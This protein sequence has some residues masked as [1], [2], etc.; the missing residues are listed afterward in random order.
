MTANRPT[1]LPTDPAW[2]KRFNAAIHNPAKKFQ[3]QLAKK[4]QLMYCVG[5]GDLIWAMTTMCPDLAFASVKLSQANSCP[6]NVHYHAVK[7]TLQYLYSTKDDGIYFW[8]TSPCPKF[9]K[10]LN[11]TVNSNKQDL[12]LTNRPE[13]P[14]SIAHMYAN[15]DCASCVKTHRSFGGTVIRLAGRTI[16]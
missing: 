15:S 7:H 16:A 10:G 8:R 1:P 6:N 11:P 12:L 5:V 4:M 3:V 9:D 2:Y 13:H 14:A